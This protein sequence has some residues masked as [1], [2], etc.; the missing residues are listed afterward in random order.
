MGDNLVRKR[1]HIASAH[2]FCKEVSMLRI[3]KNCWAEYHISSASKFCWKSIFK[4]C[5]LFST[6]VYHRI[7]NGQGYYSIHTNAAMK[8]YKTL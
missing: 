2:P 3:S 5:E 8:N 4:N 6:S 1:H 7:F